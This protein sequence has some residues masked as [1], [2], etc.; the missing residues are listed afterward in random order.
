MKPFC[1][2]LCA[3][4]LMTSLFC[5]CKV[6]PTTEYYGELTALDH[7]VLEPDEEARLT[8]KERV[9]YRRL[10]DAVI[11]R[12]ETLRLDVSPES[13]EYFTVLL[14]ENLYA[15]LLS[16]YDCSSGGAFSLSYAYS[17]EEHRDIV[18]FMDESL[19]GIVNRNS[20]ERDNKLDKILKLYYSVTDYLTYDHRTD[21]K[22]ALSDPK[23]RYPEDTVY[24]AL[25]EKTC[26]CYGFA[27]ILNF[28]MRQF[29][30]ESFT[31]YGTCHRQ[32]DSHM[33]NLFLYDGEAFFCDAAWDRS[34]DAYSK[35]THFG[36]TESE[37]LS[38]G[39]EP[40]DFASYHEKGYAE[41]KCTDKR[42]FIFRG[43]VRFSPKALH[44]FFLEDHR[45]QEYT[46]DT[47]SF[48]MK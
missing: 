42:F 2:I 15:F 4:I 33:W 48:K 16:S 34:E 9:E 5:G 36:K 26:K 44:T 13:C 37:R 28:V 41:P 17:E 32:N 29:G 25:K 8:E 31:V 30:I 35:L 39:V 27:Y 22:T 38:E 18:R 40:V 1:V 46:F 6:T 21:A 47:V 43:I 7:A 20:N 19:L 45:N 12:E 23:F 24:L 14:R 11:N 10:L 3:V